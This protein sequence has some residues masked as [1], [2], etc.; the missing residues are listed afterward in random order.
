MATGKW[1]HGLVIMAFAILLFKPEMVIFSLAYAALTA[2][3]PDYI[4]VI[5]GWT[6]A[7]A[8]YTTTYRGRPAQTGERSWPL[9]QRIS[10]MMFD[11]V[12]VPYFN[13]EI[14]RDT[15]EPFNPAEKYVFGYHPHGIIP[16]A[17]QWTSLTSKWKANFPNLQPAV[18]VSTIVHSV[19]IMRDVAQW[20]GG[21]EVSRIGFL[22]ALE[23]RKSVLLVPGGQEE[24]IGSRSDSKEVPIVTSHRG[25]IRIAL[26][27]GSNLVPIYAFGETQTFDNIKAP[28]AW[29]RWCVRMFRANLICYP[30]GIAPML[31]RSHKFTLAV[32]EPIKLPQIDH[33]SEDDV[34]HYHYMYFKALQSLF[35]KY[36]EAAGRGQDKLI[37][38][39]PLET[40]PPFP[41]TFSSPLSTFPLSPSEEKQIKT[42]DGKDQFL[43]KDNVSSTSGRI[44]SK[45]RGPKLSEFFFVVFMCVA[46]FYSALQVKL[47]GW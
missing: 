5:I 8:I 25:F 42:V 6:T 9:F 14:I 12:F 20:N 40:K 41:R 36:K 18:L 11:N 19:P 29:Q 13:L 33:P 37:F 34:A 17:C 1:Y 3:A 46:I 23:K 31:P 27:T 10:Q 47:A 16:I 39:P 45:S 2:A 26:K 38:T 21:F 15:P 22:S 7:S 44:T 43:Q 35:N 28:A 32:G 24:M 4:W 30:Y